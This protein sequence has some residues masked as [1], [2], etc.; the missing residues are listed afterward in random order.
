MALFKQH[1][2]SFCEC[3]EKKSF[4][5]NTFEE[6]ME[7]QQALLKDHKWCYSDYLDKQLLMVESIDNK[8]W[9]VIGCVEDFDLSNYLP[10]VVYG[11]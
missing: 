1:I 9:F 10:K 7:K 2:P 5:F 4:E 8:K 6:L 3:L 11:E